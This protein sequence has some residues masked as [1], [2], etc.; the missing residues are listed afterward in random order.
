MPKKCFLIMPYEP[1][2]DDVHHHILSAAQAVEP[3]HQIECL[4]LDKDQ[5]GGRIVGRLETAIRETDMCVADLSGGRSNV[6][7]EIG[8]AMALEKKVILI[9]HCGIELPFDLYDLQHLRYNRDQL[10]SSL[11]EPLTTALRHTAQQL[12][13]QPVRR[14]LESTSEEI[15]R[16]KNRIDEQ[17]RTISELHSRATASQTNH[18][19]IQKEYRQ[20]EIQSAEQA[21]TIAELRRSNDQF[22]SM[23]RPL[24][25]K[26]ETF[27]KSSTPWNPST[28]EGAWINVETESH[29]YFKNI[30]GQLVAPYCYAANTQLSGVYHDFRL[31]PSGEYVFARFDWIHETIAGF[32][33]LKPVSAD[34]LSGAWWYDHEKT[35]NIN[36]MPELSSG[37]S[38]QVR[39]LPT[40]KTP[41]WAEKFFERVKKHGVAGAIQ[42]LRDLGAD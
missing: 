13:D 34:F 28:Y 9:S 5:Q 32:A 36:Q 2:F 29:M 12:S 37:W 11:T 6:M 41:A 3:G 23:L 21:A 20:R 31:D 8:F 22:H 17:T 19:L 38:S 33:F 30:D 39:R 35:A 7:W 26:M 16:F 14:T 1:K 40:Q 42:V 27:P 10:R 4:R 24:V 18:L 15:V 25:S